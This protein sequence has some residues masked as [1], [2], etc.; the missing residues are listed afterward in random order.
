MFIETKLVLSCF[1]EFDSRQYLRS[2]GG[3]IHVSYFF[4]DFSTGYYEFFNALLPTMDTLN[5][6]AAVDSA[7]RISMSER[8]QNRL[9]QR[10]PVHPI[11]VKAQ[12]SDILL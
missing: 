4:N 8:C 3:N 10:F 12:E 2:F 7:P 1:L 11:T 9:I 5:K 6:G